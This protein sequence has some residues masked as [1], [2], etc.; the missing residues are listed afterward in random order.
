MHGLATLK[1]SLAG[2]NDFA[3]GGAE[4]GPTAIEGVNPG[5]LLFQVAQYAVLHPT[6]VGGA[7]ST[8]S[9][10]AATTSLRRST[11]STRA[12]SAPAWSATAIAQAE[13]NT[14]HAVEVAVCAR[15]AQP[16]VLRGAGSGGWPPISAPKDRPG[17]ISP[18]VL[19]SRLIRRCS[20]TSFRSSTWASRFTMCSTYADLDLV[21]S[22]SFLLHGNQY[23]ISFTNVKNMGW[24]GNFTSSSSGNPE[25]VLSRLSASLT[26]SIRPPWRI[27]LTADRPSPTIP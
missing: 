26:R 16:L 5:D 6:P 2:G 19:R 10:S 13:A 12:R 9:T 4:T 27:S 3:F 15:R 20:P 1:P 25:S 18:A 17:K 11:S 24:S 7:R 8:R 22:N 14:V 21:A 23:G